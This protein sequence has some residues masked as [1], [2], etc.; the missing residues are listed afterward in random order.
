M[1]P[2]P[3]CAPY[4]VSECLRVVSSSHPVLRAFTIRTHH[5]DPNLFRVTLTLKVELRYFFRTPYPIHECI[6][7]LLR[8][9]IRATVG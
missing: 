7:E 5:L 2:Y 6:K 1:H 4:I 9:L 8:L 3:K